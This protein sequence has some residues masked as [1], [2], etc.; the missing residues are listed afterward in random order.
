MRDPLGG[1]RVTT[2]G[3]RWMASQLC[4]LA[5]ECCDGKLMMILEGGYDLVAL[6]EG[7]EAMLEELVSA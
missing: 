1:M 2:D 4:H 3:F 5:T 7:S 6:R